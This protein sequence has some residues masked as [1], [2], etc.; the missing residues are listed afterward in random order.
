[1][2]GVPEVTGLSQAA[3]ED[4]ITAANL[5]V[6]NVTTEPSDTVPTGQVIRQNPEGGAVAVTGSFVDIVVSL[7]IQLS[8]FETWSGGLAA[9]EDTDSDG[10][11]NAVAWAL[12]AAGPNENA[13]ARLPTL[14][15]TSDPAY[16]LFTFHRSDA[17]EADANTTI[18]VEYGN[19]LLGWTS[20][21]H[22]GD[23][24]II[25]I[26][27]GSPADT[28]VVKLKRSTLGAGGTIFARLKVAV[29]PTSDLGDG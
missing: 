8:A 6:G 28:V 20:A 27:D 22:D 7:G 29:T 1:M 9:N 5:A 18:S 21:V 13:I 15:N 4:A 10:I 25:E 3:A 26:T 2:V 12:G 19:D 16:V 24:V 11:P 23:G 14:D 17:A